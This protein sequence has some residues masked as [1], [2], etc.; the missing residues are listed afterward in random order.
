MKKKLS[1]IALILVGLFV[2]A[3]I[4]AC[5]PKHTHNYNSWEYN[6]TYHWRKCEC[7]SAIGN[8]SHEYDND[9][10]CK[11]CG[12]EKG[13]DI[14]KHTH[15]FSKEWTYDETYHWH[16]ATCEHAGKIN[17]KS[18]H[19][20]NGSNSCVECGYK[21]EFEFTKILLLEYYE[22]ESDALNSI[23][24]ENG[25]DVTAVNLLSDV[26]DIPDT[27]EKLCEYHQVILVNVS[28]NDLMH[29][30]FVEEE[31]GTQKQISFDEMLNDYA[32]VCGGSVF[33]VGGNLQGRLDPYTGL[34]LPYAFDL[35]EKSE[36]YEAMLPVKV[37]SFTPP[38]A[39]MFIFDTSGGIRS[40]YLDA[41]K[42]GVIN[43][44]ESYNSNMSYKDYVGIMT[45]ESSAMDVELTSMRDIEQIRNKISEIQR[46]DSCKYR[47][48]L[49]R[50]GPIL[51][52]QKN[53]TRRHIVLITNGEP[54]DRLDDGNGLQPYGPIVKRNNHEAGIT[55]SVISYEKGRYADEV[56]KAAEEYGGGKY[57]EL[58]GKNDGLYEPSGANVIFEA[59]N[60]AIEDITVDEVVVKEFKPIA[61][62]GTPILQGVDIEDIPSLKGYYG[63]YELT[64]AVTHL[65]S[66]KT[67]N[68]PLYSEWYYG[69]GKV[70]A[71]MSTLSGDEWSKEFVESDTGQRI[72]CN[73]VAN[74]MPDSVLRYDSDWRSLK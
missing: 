26:Q 29:I 43:Y 31:S 33:F 44:L 27:M 47:D 14:T 52:A 49:M 23:L 45:L 7:G 58:D 55:M 9:N 28:A 17:V 20:F 40:K 70:G 46:G 62:F 41:A 66:D 10:K 1:I 15:T 8:E 30:T 11:V 42:A 22:G 38:R 53:V 74:L 12:Y 39:V 51:A 54:Y 2:I 60:E 63:A 34:P 4:A 6:G 67:N 57:V 24:V 72:I 32:N 59:V 35:Y 13:G 56:K 65:L 68:V 73:I 71:F 3:S 5:A 37:K 18:K 16:E 50:A 25:Y 21:F 19:S 64:G 69:K 61:A 48:A 36:H